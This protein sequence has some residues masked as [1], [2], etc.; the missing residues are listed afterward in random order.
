[1]SVRTRK[2][3][4]PGTLSPV[5]E[6]PRSIE[7]PEYAWK[8][9]ANEGREPWVQTPETIEKMRLASKM[10][11]QALQAVIYQI[12]V[13]V[14]TVV[15]GVG[16]VILWFGVAGGDIG[17]M[18]DWVEPVWIAFPIGVLGPSILYALWGAA[19][20]LGGHDFRYAIV[21]KLVGRRG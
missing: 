14:I 20:C 21:G 7:R 6:V 4:V 15:G 8:K 2:P 5:R 19:R 16:W 1:M 3:L 10:A 13:L 12:A 11:A 17:S 9:T 18:P